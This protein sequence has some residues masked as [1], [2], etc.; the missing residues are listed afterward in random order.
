M[1][2]KKYCGIL[3][4]LVPPDP[5]GATS[6][7]TIGMPIPMGALKV[8]SVTICRNS[9]EEVVPLITAADRTAGPQKEFD[10]S[11][12]YI[13]NLDPLPSYVSEKEDEINGGLSMFIAIFF[14]LAVIFLAVAV[15]CVFLML[16]KTQE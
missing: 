8:T 3:L 11:V 2:P 15:V 5:T 13:D 9:M 7:A 1:L 4:T 16:R 6:N 10:H 12:G 14:I